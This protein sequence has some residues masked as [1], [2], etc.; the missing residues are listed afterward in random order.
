ML[1][2]PISNVKTYIFLLKPNL[3]RPLTPA[4]FL[5]VIL[6]SFAEPPL[7][8]VIRTSTHPRKDSPTTLC[9]P[10]KYVSKPWARISAYSYSVEKCQHIAVWKYCNINNKKYSIN[11]PIWWAKFR[12]WREIL[13]VI[14]FAWHERYLVNGVDGNWVDA[15]RTELV[16]GT[17]SGTMA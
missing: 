7:R 8:R 12:F 3:F 10:R 2:S 6:S 16:M 5:K 9:T 17:G 4:V 13:G 14:C 11:Y 1:T 15:T